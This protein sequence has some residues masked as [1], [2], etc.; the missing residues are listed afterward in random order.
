MF[1][2]NNAFK[3]PPHQDYIHIQGAEATYTAWFPLGD[4]P[5][6]LGGLAVLAGSHRAGVLPVSPAPGAG[7]VGVETEDLALS[8]VTGDFLLGDVLLFHS[9]TVH[10]ALDNRSPDRLRLSV[11]FRYQGMSA[12][13]TEG[14]LKPHFSRLPWDDIYAGWKSHRFQYYWR[15]SD[16]RIVAPRPRDELIGRGKPSSPANDPLAEAERPGGKRS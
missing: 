3:T 8:W 5:A 6:D 14:S 10:R 4:C 13:V 12:P 11:D 16:L 2:N 7:G 9:H 1:P 15:R